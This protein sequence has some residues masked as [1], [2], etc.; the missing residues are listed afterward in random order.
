MVASTAVRTRPSV[1]T[2]GLLTALIA[3]GYGVMFTVLDDFRDDYGI[4]EGALGLVVAT[5]F[6]ASF[7]A[8]V[9]IAPLADRGHARR[10]VAIG[11]TLNIAGMLAMAVS[12]TLATLLMARLVMGLGAGTTIPSVR[13]IVILSDPGNLGHN[14][15]RLLAADVAGFAIG[16]AISAIL[17]GPFG[18]P[19]PFIV[20]AIATLA[21]LPV[22]F[23]VQITETRSTEHQ[24]R[25]AFDLLRIRP[26]AGA[27]A[28]GMAMFMMI[29]TFD[30]LWVLVLSDLGTADWLANFGVTM[31]AI[32]LFFLGAAGGRL[33]QRVGPFRLGSVGLLLGAGF[34]FVY[35]QL[36]SGVVMTV[37]AV[38]HS[39]SDGLTI[40]STGVAVG[41]TAP[42]ERQA[43]AQGMLGGV[44]T[45]TGG[46]TAI[47]AGTMYDEFG[48][49]FVFTCCAVGM[50]L[51]ALT[52]LAL[53]GTEWRSRPAP[54]EADTAPAAA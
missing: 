38:F 48:G 51:L 41:L 21:C 14:L 3:A 5:G 24:A 8:Q 53:A 17:V 23:R 42:K 25:F 1:F 29:G 43:A 39:I 52:S 28:M 13:R 47:A 2:F 46:L 36:E 16:P 50:A 11:L 9:F 54:V 22:V 32:P 31:F 40:S 4:S 37:V 35:G 49:G 7:V 30:A 19:A 20:I 34:M 26:Y 44:Q 33:A 12:T 15:G 27:L 10:L 18:I 45:L 6:F